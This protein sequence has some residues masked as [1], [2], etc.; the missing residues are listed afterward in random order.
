M[1][2]LHAVYRQN[3]NHTWDATIEFHPYILVENAPCMESAREFL[4]IYIAEELNRGTKWE[5][6][7]ESVL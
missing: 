2:K 1:L 6:V 7:K 4:A 3:Y 5:I